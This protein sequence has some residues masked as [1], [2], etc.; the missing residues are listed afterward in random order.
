MLE[1]LELG[2]AVVRAAGLEPG[3]LEQ[4]GRLLEPALVLAQHA[5][6]IGDR[7]RPHSRPPG[8]RARLERERLRSRQLALEQD[9]AAGR[10]RH[11]EHLRGL[12]ARPAH[13][14]GA[15]HLA[16]R[17][18]EVSRLPAQV[19]EH[20]EPEP[21][22]LGG[23]LR[24]GALGEPLELARG[25]RDVLGPARL[26]L[27]LQQLQQQARLLRLADLRRVAAPAPGD[28][29]GILVRALAQEAAAGRGAGPRRGGML[30]GERRVVRELGRRGVRR[31]PRARGAPRPAG[32]SGGDGAARARCRRRAEPGRG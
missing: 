12:V 23:A 14:L 29:A 13:D 28:R 31:V 20:V 5:L 2:H 21:R 15:Q 18:G 9:Q 3:L 30:A 4:L 24:E 7:G 27:D 11:R 16:L 22:V 26:Q 32:A 25:G 6:G 19:R 1:R 10:F 8:A 17:V